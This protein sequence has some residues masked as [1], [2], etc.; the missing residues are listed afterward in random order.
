MPAIGVGG[1]ERVVR[2]STVYVSSLGRESV[3]TGR[4]P[5]TSRHPQT[6]RHPSSAFRCTYSTKSFF[7]A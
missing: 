7:T 4:H 3:Q 6:G 2:M 5:K 1:A